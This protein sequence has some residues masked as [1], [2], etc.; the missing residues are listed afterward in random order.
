[1]NPLPSRRA[2][3]LAGL[4]VAVSM[5]GPARAADLSAKDFVEGIYRAYVSKGGKGGTGISTGTD[6]A[7]RRYFSPSVA[8]LIIADAR[9]AKKR[10]EVPM[11]DG[12]PFVGHQDWEITAFTVDII[13]SGTTAKGSVTFTNMGKP[14]RISL[15]LVKTPNGWRIDDAVWTEGSLRGIY[16]KP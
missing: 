15:A 1:M 11:L 13:E 12:D 3:V 4:A 5:Q 10:D 2:V 14:E 16:K 7:V 6:A 8:A 9:Q